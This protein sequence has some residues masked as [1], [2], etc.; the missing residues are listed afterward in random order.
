MAILNCHD[1]KRVQAMLGHGKKNAVRI[2]VV[3]LRYMHPEVANNN[4]PSRVQHS[5]SNRAGA[6]SAN[7][8]YTKK[9]AQDAQEN[10]MKSRKGSR[11]RKNSV[12]SYPLSNQDMW[13]GQY[14]IGPFGGQYPVPV[15][16]R[17]P[18]SKASK[19]QRG[20]MWIRISED[21]T[22]SQPWGWMPLE[23]SYEKALNAL[24]GKVVE[25]DTAYLFDDQY[26][27][28]PI[29]GISAQG[30]R[31]H[32]WAV[33]EVINDQRRGKGTS[34]WSGRIGPMKGP[35]A[36]EVAAA[37]LHDWE[38]SRDR[39]PEDSPSIA[40]MRPF[41]VYAPAKGAAWGAWK[42]L[43]TIRKVFKNGNF[44]LASGERI[45]AGHYQ[46][47]PVVGHKLFV[48]PDGHHRIA[49][50]AKDLKDVVKHRAAR[51]NP[52]Y[53]T[54][55]KPG[56]VGY[57]AEW[58]GVSHAPKARGKA[59][60]ECGGVVHREGDSHYCPYCDNYVRTVSKSAR[61]N[62]KGYD[63]DFSRELSMFDYHAPQFEQTTG[64]FGVSEAFTHGLQ[65][66]NRR[67]P[68]RRR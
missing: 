12:L 38:T 36:A 53:E 54:K 51:R 60:A 41:R 21:P 4:A 61:R 58:S 15:T 52:R 67:N 7:P 64:P 63:T 2:P 25:V 16:R 33:E 62:G 45:H 44:L 34:N 35:K 9:S 47:R 50:S 39:K 56:D 59:C 14:E 20:R 65:P 46:G 19:A 48:D 13:M 66:A 55:R 57:S 32:D 40:R 17:N 23:R 37:S 5:K 11:A 29:P 18:A 28:H 3:M 31:I 26:N 42:S 1:V 6:K 68:R 43:G 10:A 8:R 22:R 30:L 27:T 24:R 49:A